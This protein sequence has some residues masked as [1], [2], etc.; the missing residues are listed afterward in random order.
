MHRNALLSSAASHTP[1]HQIHSDVPSIRLIA[2][3]PS[4]SGLS[5]EANTS[6]NTSWSAVPSVP[7]PLAPRS[8]N[9]PPRRK[10][11]PK[12]SKLGLLGSSGNKDKDKERGK[13][14]SD[15]I[16]RVGGS[17]SAR[18]GFDIYVDPTDDPEMGEIIMVKKKK[19]RAGLDGLR[20]GS[21]GS[22][23]EEVTNIPSAAPPVTNTTKVKSEG[24]EKWWTIGRGRKDSKEKE[25]QKEKE[26][27]KVK[28]R[29][30]PPRSKTPEPFRSPPETQSRARF[31]SLDSGMLLTTASTISPGYS[32]R[33]NSTPQLLNTQDIAREDDRPSQQASYSRAGTPTLG[34]FLAPPGA[35]VGLHPSGAPSGQNPNQNSIALRA[36][37]SMRSLARIGSWA[38]LKNGSGPGEGGVE[39]VETTKEKGKKEDV[40]KKSTTKKRKENTDKPEKEKTKKVKEKSAKSKLSTIRNSSSSF[41]AG[42]L[43]ASPH[44]DAKTQ[45]LGKKK[46]SILGLGL[47]STMRLP[48]VRSGST[49]SSIGAGA[50][51]GNNRLSVDSAVM[52]ASRGRSGSNA[53]SIISSGSSLRPLSTTSSISRASSGSSAGSVKWDEEGLETVKEQRRKEKESKRKSQ[54]SEVQGTRR[55]SRESRHSAEGRKRTPLSDVFPGVHDSAPESPAP[56]FM[57]REPPLVTVEEA[58]SDGHSRVEDSP[59]ITPSKK[60]RPRPVSEQML[61]KSRPK[62]I[63][64]EDGGDGV[65]S[66]LSAATNDLEKLINHLDLEATPGTTPGTPESFHWQPPR[67]D[68]DPVPRLP[69]EDS[70]TKKT[71]RKDVTSISSLR[72]YGQSRSKEATISRSSTN[73]AL[74]GQQIAPWPMLN[75]MFPPK[76]SPKKDS[77]DVPP[78][79][80]KKVSHKRT[81]SPPNIQI[82][83][84]PPPTLRPLRP[85]KSRPVIDSMKP[86]GPPPSAALPPVTDSPLNLNLA[87]IRA[88]SA[89]TFG[90]RSSSRGANSSVSSMDAVVAAPPNPV[91]K[92]RTHARNRSS[93]LSSQMGSSQGSIPEE[94]YTTSRPL[95]PGAKRMLGMKGTMG[96]SDVSAYAMDDLDISDPDSDIPDELQH[97]LAAQERDDTL[98]FRP[99]PTPSVESPPQ[100]PHVEEEVDSASDP[101]PLDVPIFLA[102]VT[103]DHDNHVELAEFTSEDEADTKR[104]FDF[105]GE[106]NKLNES[107]ASDRR[108]FVEQLENA[109]RTPAKV[110]LRYD[111]SMNGSLQVE[112]PPLPPLPQ[113]VKAQSNMKSEESTSISMDVTDDSIMST[114]A[115]ASTTTNQTSS[116]EMESISVS[117]LLDHK[118]PTLLPGSDSLGSNINV[119]MDSPNPLK[120]SSSRGSRPSDG[121]LNKSFKFGGAPKPSPEPKKVEELTL[122]DIIPPPSHVRNLSNSSLLVDDSV[123]NSIMAKATE[124]PQRQ[125]VPRPRVNSDSSMKQSTRSNVQS[126]I[127]YRHSRHESGFSFTGFDSFEEVRRGFEFHDYRPAFYPPPPSTTF[128]RRGAHGRQEST[129]SFASISSVG[130]VLNPGV[131]DPF[132][133]GL[134]S[135]RER[136]SSEDMSS[137]SM[138]MSIDDTFS[139]MHHPSY[140]R[141][142]VESDASSFY[143]NPALQSSNSR[144]HRRHE[145]NMSVVSQGPPVSL[146]NRSFAA[147]R[148]NDSSTSASSI[149]HSYAMHGASGGRAA[150]ARHRRGASTDSVASD[151]S[152]MRLGRPGIGDKMFDAPDYGA[153][154]Q[155]ISASPPE[156]TNA[157]NYTDRFNTQS[158]LDSILDADQQSVAEDSLF[159]KTGQRSSVSSDSVFGNDEDASNQLLPP[160]YRPLSSISIQS[161]HS[162][163]KDDDT[164]LS[165][166]GGGHVRRRSV[167]SIIQASPCL[168]VGKRKQP[169]GQI[170]TKKKEDGPA[171]KTQPSIASASSSTFGFGSERMIRARRGILERQSLEES[172]L[173]AEGEDLSFSFGS[174]P[175]FSRP[176]P[177]GRS[178]SST[179][180]SSSSGADTPPLSIS[181][182]SSISEG[183]QSSIDIAH[184]Q[185]I[186]ANTSHPA[187]LRPRNRAR[188]RGQGHRRRISQAR[189]S[190]SSV[191]ETIE[192]ELSSPESSPNNSFSMS[193][194]SS[195]TAIQPVFIVDPET[196]SVHSMDSLWDDERGVMALRRYYD[197]RHEAE[198]TVK[199]SRRVWVDTAFSLYALQSFEPPRHP[200]GMQAMLA[201]SVQTY[202]PL[203][204]E[205]RPRRKRTSSRPSPYPAARTIKVSISPESVRSIPPAESLPPVP[206]IANDFMKNVTNSPLQPKSINSN[207]VPTPR[208]KVFKKLNA[209][210]TGD[211]GAE[212]PFNPEDAFGVPKARPRV[213]S[214]A[215]RT[216]LG[217]SKRSTGKSSSDL[218][219]N[220]IGQG[221][222]TTPNESLR[223]SRPRPR[224][225][226][227][228]ARPQSMRA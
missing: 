55:T 163:M 211:T 134:P 125:P 195:P 182:G 184:L 9:E 214:A 215:R 37:R 225:R 181:D 140:R 67:R 218:K 94:E 206:P 42:A 28:A 200:A 110:D 99:P 114:D 199:E 8:E 59:L 157:D 176:A 117:R 7:S 91:F 124:V 17:S 76:D 31:N 149:A 127:Q 146:Y 167:G 128:T 201:D 51:S 194:K 79:K 74:I 132:D 207:T 32:S 108:S 178:R 169:P 39:E 105:T 130:Y 102:N 14:L 129:I 123:L 166:I 92:P 188:A 82:E 77:G 198:Y 40:K 100:V 131:P 152:A 121:E 48:S 168:R 141:R 66:I 50:N 44:P 38:Q 135:L 219:E 144:G 13:D 154:L 221:T 164:M 228:P 24:K 133:Y 165:M 103:D 116:L 15:V 63:H 106:L 222:G 93:L 126:V 205:L 75:A 224:G 209:K 189:A 197:L 204:S 27:E 111:F 80:V 180:T 88:P 49:T 36:M 122:S 16:R 46:R 95:A 159:E 23:L 29:P 52:L 26:K 202:G 58:T 171:V 192:E 216:A 69:S 41:E 156:S 109:F 45:S 20:W 60:V 158:Y 72:P 43:T 10:L 64:E 155:S 107:G 6:I 115:Q 19:S 65:M 137:I 210:Q 11:V 73:S 104:S 83:A 89:L 96:G 177:T 22:P 147:H 173:M 35:N 118:E 112:V 183:S 30:D 191:Y 87:T 70:P 71:L 1:S 81:M 145:S 136:P 170:M 119:A 193:K 2:A 78:L 142:R 84:T 113:A 223:L 186:L 179:C 18:R 217:W 208:A 153:P 226:P 120:S 3:T 56:S 34:G 160:T 185:E 47:P 97:I 227:T 148:R 57:S 138:S 68:S 85:A 172:A 151:F 62:P 4:A 12:K 5:S 203:P 212:E 220:S 161:I 150:W 53:A 86:L 196:S 139:F 61:M 162:P 101:E 187:S 25:K 90:S 213:G 54:E 98:S 190:R 143:F 174:M 175:V 21:D 33:N